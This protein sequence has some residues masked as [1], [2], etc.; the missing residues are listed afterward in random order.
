[1]SKQPELIVLHI[2]PST[3]YIILKIYGHMFKA[4]IQN[5]LESIFLCTYKI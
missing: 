1:M 4:I 3:N 2:K 5:F